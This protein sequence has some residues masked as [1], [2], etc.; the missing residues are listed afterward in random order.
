[1]MPWYVF[2]LV[3]RPPAARAGRG[4]AGALALRRVRGGFGVV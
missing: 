2:A 4:L 3:D 1:M